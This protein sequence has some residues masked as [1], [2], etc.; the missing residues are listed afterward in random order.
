MDSGFSFRWTPL[1]SNPDLPAKS[2]QGS[3]EQAGE[4]R[5]QALFQRAPQPLFLLNRQRRV[6]FVNKAWESLTGLAIGQ[7]RG[8]ACTRRKVAN[9]ASRE[10]LA[11]ALCPPPEVLDG[12]FAKVCIPPPVSGDHS[13][14]WDI[15][16]F[17]VGEGRGLLFI[18]GKITAVSA[19]SQPTALP[20]PEKLIP[21]RG[22]LSERYRFDQ[23]SDSS[24]L[25]RRVAD[26][27]RLACRTRS[28]VLIVGEPGA[29]KHW[30]A[31]TIHYQG[32]TAEKHFTALRCAGI[33]ESLLDGILFGD[34]GL[35][36]QAGLGTLF[37][38]E[39]ACLP[40][41]LQLRLCECLE[42]LGGDSPRIIAGCCRPPES[43]VQAGR[44]LDQLH[45]ALAILV[46]ILP[47]LR[48]RRTE[49]PSLVERL[50][51]RLRL[52]SDQRVS[53]L[54]SN[55]WEVLQAY[56]W[57]GNLRELSA[58]LAATSARASGSQIDVPDLPAYLRLAVKMDQTSGGGSDDRRLSL[59]S[60]LEK[61]ERRLILHALKLAQGN[62]SRA[63]ELLS[64]WRPRLLRRMEALGIKDV[65]TNEPN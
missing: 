45:F 25:M 49:L 43:D 48:E 36:K 18:L 9:A 35:L 58:V 38:Q 5:W 60:L 34:F 27:V 54:T 1:V 22:R 63:A 15:E 16:F 21:L 11:R 53:G 7:I 31:R 2:D 8:L 19:D 64:I 3:A 24:P 12:K 41:D 30:L 65:K 14:R 52:Q 33:P 39:P 10:A 37:I 29:G 50:L 47:P 32:I 17:P 42:E 23:L 40:R 28:P 20:V 6:L 26:Q 57:P 61:A 46:I 56:A 13:R 62:K 4:F 44:L 55:A 51:E 59:D